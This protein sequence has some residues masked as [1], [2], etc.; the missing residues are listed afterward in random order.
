MASRKITR[1]A[2]QAP[3]PSRDASAQGLGDESDAIMSPSRQF[4]G[5]EDSEL[6]GVDEDTLI[7]D[8]QVNPTAGL[9]AKEEVTPIGGN[10]DQYRDSY[11]AIAATTEE[12]ESHTNR[13]ERLEAEIQANLTLV[14]LREVE[15]R[16][17]ETLKRLR[18]AESALLAAS[19]PEA[20]ISRPQ[21]EH[22]TALQ[23]RN[24]HEPRPAPPRIDDYYGKTMREQT[25]FIRACQL[26]HNL[27]PGYFETDKLKIL[28]AMPY[29]K[30]RVADAWHR[31]IRTH[32]V[33]ATYTWD[34]F[35][36]WLKNEIDDKEVR[37][38]ATAQ[39][40]KEA[41][42]GDRQGPADLLTYLETLELDLPPISDDQKLQNFWTA[43]RPDLQ[44]KMSLT[45]Q[46]WASRTDCVK[47]AT[48]LYNATPG[49]DSRSTRERSSHDGHTE[50]DS[51][52]QDRRPNTRAPEQTTPAFTPR[53]YSGPARNENG[54]RSGVNTI[55]PRDV[56][57]ITCHN[58]KKV[59]HYASNCTEKQVNAISS[60]PAKNTEASL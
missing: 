14:R 37:A 50:R 16:H 11:E 38:N 53:P 60:A 15:A 6:S 27:M 10:A 25:L 31:V 35:D 42:Q 18:R 44:Q 55:P 30:G 21:V 33:P 58:C 22:T 51:K 1:S 47:L 28:T 57:R 48:R 26:Q 4:D 8:A 20:P 59:G 54:P 19:D 32:G 43:L 36:E 46:T 9:E 24:H 49:R 17:E 34:M 29:L 40:L 12:Q 3:L 52:R 45:G 2:S 23:T 39:K 56:S 7:Q 13:I 5:D 41:R